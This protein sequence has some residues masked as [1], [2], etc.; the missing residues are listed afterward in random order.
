M[1]YYPDIFIGM[2]P[3]NIS[4]DEHRIHPEILVVTEN[5]LEVGR[6]LLLLKEN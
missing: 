2:C 5:D 3:R 4:P 1:R 6:S